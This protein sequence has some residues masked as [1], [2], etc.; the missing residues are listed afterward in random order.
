[1]D[2][3]KVESKE[4]LDPQHDWLVLKEIAHEE[5]SEGGIVLARAGEYDH[6]KTDRERQDH[7]A[8][9]DNP[10]ANVRRNTKRYEVL[11]VGPGS[12]VDV[13]DE[14]H[15]AVFLRKPMCCEKGD[16]VLVQEGA[17]P[18][19]VGGEILYMCHD[20]LI[21]AKIKQGDEPGKEIF[22]PQHDYIFAKQ[23]T[24]L[25]TSKG[26]IIM[27]TQSDQTGNKALP[28]RW[29]ALGVGDGP[30]ALC[31]EKGKIPGWKRRPMS[32]TQDDVFAFEGAGF[33]VYV[34][35]MPMLCVQNYQVAAIFKEA[36]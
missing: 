36:A 6:L 16:V 3:A 12:Y 31:Q 33:S 22:D 14:L 27:A 2:A 7:R 30:W 32:V 35:G 28:D 17:A 25:K 18:I 26:G 1:M 9:R 34:G 20:Y 5:V 24:E 15:D 10:G 29:Q 11:A 4:F 21:L 13:A 8:D 19:T 23:A